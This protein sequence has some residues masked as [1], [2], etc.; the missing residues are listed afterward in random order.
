[1]KILVTGGAGYIGSHCCIELLG[2]GQDVVVVDNFSNSNPEA[3][4]NIGRIAG[5]AFDFVEADLRDEAAMDRIFAEHSIGAVI[6]FAGLKAVGESVEM[7][8]EYYDNNLGGS[9]SLFK[10]MRRHAV[11]KIVFSSS[12][13]V[14]GMHNPM[15]LK[16]DYPTS[17]VNPYG[18]TKVVIE[19]MLQDIA[20]A[21]P[22]WSVCLL[23]YFNPIGAHES[24]LLGEEPNGTPN[25]LLPYIAMVAAG[26]MDF[27]R[28]FG[29]DYDTVDGTGVRDYIHV[30]DLASGHLAALDYLAGHSGAI[31]INLGTGKGTSVLQM[32]R[33]FEKAS[34]KPIP[35][36]IEGRRAGDIAECYADVARA[37]ALLGWQAVRSIEQMC[38]DGWRFVRRRSLG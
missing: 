5:R 33:A 11:K 12:A 4:E 6:H 1:M 13:T 2:S 26:K 16:E 15:P 23:R 25:N 9:L 19:R 14:Y 17:A 28:V 21:N 20:A 3:L 32:I 34:G 7:P 27:L 8:L 31:P 29:D 24:G 30:L 37:K 38:E 18:Y 36:R 22:D 35:Y 10:A